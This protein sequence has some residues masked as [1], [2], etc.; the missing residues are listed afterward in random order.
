MAKKSEPWESFLAQGVTGDLEDELRDALLEVL[1]ADNIDGGEALKEIIS[2][3]IDFGA[4][5]PK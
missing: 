1:N 4:K 5:L 2:A 3:A